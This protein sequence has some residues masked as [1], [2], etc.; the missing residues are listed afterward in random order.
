MEAFTVSK[1]KAAPFA[2]TSNNRESPMLTIYLK[3]RGKG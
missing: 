3:P 2:N 1:S